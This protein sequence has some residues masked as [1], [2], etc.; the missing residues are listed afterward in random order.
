M[1]PGREAK[2]GIYLSLDL[3]IAGSWPVI[4]QQQQAMSVWT[5]RKEK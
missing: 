2:A 1:S 4:S 5:S 3:L